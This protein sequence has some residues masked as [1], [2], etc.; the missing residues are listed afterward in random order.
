MSGFDGEFRFSK[1]RRNY[2]TEF[3]RRKQKMSNV[4][5]PY[6][7][8]PSKIEFVNDTY[9]GVF[10]KRHAVILAID[11][12]LE[13]YPSMSDFMKSLAV[14]KIIEYCDEYV[15]VLRRENRS[16]K[17]LTGVFNLRHFAKTEYDRLIAL[18]KATR[19]RQHHQQAQQNAARAQNDPK[20]RV[21][22]RFKQ[23]MHDP[24][25]KALG[26]IQDRGNQPDAKELHDGEILEVL[27]QMH[28]A[29]HELKK[30]QNKWM[31]DYTTDKNFWDYLEQYFRDNPQESIYQVKYLDENERRAYQIT[32]N[33]GQ[34]MQ[35]RQ[36]FNTQGMAINKP[37]PNQAWNRAIF[38]MS[39]DGEI[40]SGGSFSNPVP[41]AN[42]NVDRDNS[43][44]I[45]HHSSFLMGKPVLCAG[46][47]IVENGG[48]VTLSP[49]SG[50]YRPPVDLFQ[51]FLK[52]MKRQGVILSAITVE[53]SFGGANHYYNAQ[54]F[55][56]ANQ[57]F[58]S[59]E[60]RHNGVPLRELRDMRNSHSYRRPLPPTPVQQN[61][62][63]QQFRPVNQMPINQRQRQPIPV[64]SGRPLPPT[65]SSY[66]S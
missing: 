14:F 35:G 15:A 32:V 36:P 1:Q 64:R 29:G 11:D 46:E 65:P 61:R 20:F 37:R 13:K 17:R 42:G 47:W 43:G 7:R 21:Q 18:I 30:I 63:P 52:T 25:F 4:R 10:A 39:V 62:A 2:L 60:P 54:E 33:G 5:M 23:A 38:V 22:Q 49:Q 58:M 31:A 28:R 24:R 45:L 57:V 6:K 19:S 66:N 27:D 53:W 3:V 50:H 44:D 8:M 48:I 51:K 12:L 40:Y 9:A 59:C 26:S 41:K 56:D 55:A 34:L 16:S